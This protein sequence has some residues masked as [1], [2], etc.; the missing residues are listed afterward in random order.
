MAETVVETFEIIHVEQNQRERLFAAPV[1]RDFFVQ[2][3]LQRAV[4]AQSRQ[5]VARGL[6]EQARVGLAQFAALLL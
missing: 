1:A 2:S 5:A 6:V 4:V 3:L